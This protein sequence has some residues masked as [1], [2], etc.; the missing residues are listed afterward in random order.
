M[1]TVNLYNIYL[2]TFDA[3]T[4][5]NL[6]Y[7]A[8]NLGG[9]PWYNIQ[10]TYVDRDGVVFQ[11]NVTWKK[12]VSVSAIGVEANFDPTS[13]LNNLFAAGTLP[14]DSTGVYTIFFRDTFVAGM[15]TEWCGYHYYYSYGGVVLK[16]SLVG[17]PTSVRVASVDSVALLST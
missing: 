11:N 13:I 9:S 4:Q 17:D 2:G 5:P 6:D 3:A 12:S 10:T 8:Q 14:V 15:K 1:L 16:Y 7:F